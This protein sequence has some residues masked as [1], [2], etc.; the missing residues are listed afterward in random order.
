MRIEGSTD[1][2]VFQTYVE[3]V[4]VPNLWPG[5][6]VLIDNLTIH[7]N[8]KVRKAIEVVRGSVEPKF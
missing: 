4:L 7:K 5:A 6:V 2:A 3:S 1:S 8:V